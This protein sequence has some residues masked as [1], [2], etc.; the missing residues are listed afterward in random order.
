MPSQSA[1]GRDWL[2]NFADTE[3][4]PM[5]LLLDSLQIVS[6]T[7]VNFGLK[8]QIESLAPE[9]RGGTGLLVPVLSLSDI[10][11]ALQQARRRD[12]ETGAR[13]SPVEAATS[14]RTH[15][16]WVTYHPG[17]P[18]SATPGSE[19]PV[20]NLVRDLT[21]ERPGEEPSH[22]LHPASD[23]DALRDRK[24]RLLVLVTDYSGSGTQVDRL[25]GPS[26]ATSA[27]GVGGRSAGSRWSSSPTR[28]PWTL[29]GLVLLPGMSIA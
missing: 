25:L 18:I 23:L 26:Y 22:W 20:G 29:V 21:G 13:P 12:E 5:A 19:G 11:Q 9:L 6:P 2:T 7:A 1:R 3:R 17:M 10:D 27:S 8:T 15:T 16:A 4:P 14:H 28:W 24:C